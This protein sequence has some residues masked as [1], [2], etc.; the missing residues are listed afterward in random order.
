MFNNADDT[1][2]P[3]ARDADDAAPLVAAEGRLEDRVA[4]SLP[5]PGCGVTGR[6]PAG[7][8]SLRVGGTASL[9]ARFRGGSSR[10]D[11]N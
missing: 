4:V 2:A 1:E 9:H 3:A 8:L 10:A 11:S 5:G 7:R 6:S